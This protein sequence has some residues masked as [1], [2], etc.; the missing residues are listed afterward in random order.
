ME[1]HRLSFGELLKHEAD[2]AE[3]IVDDGLE[4]NMEMVEEYHHWIRE[5]LASP[6]ALLINKINK[7]TYTFEAQEKIA[8][9]PSI[10]AMAVITYSN[11]SRVTTEGLVDVPREI[12]WNIK[13][14]GS[15][16]KGFDWLK[17]QLAQ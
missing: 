7:Y 14:F 16:S 3:V 9:E 13:I 2:L 8:T 15:R 11:M 5:H 12:Q 10:R 1:K 6:C 4:M 17:E